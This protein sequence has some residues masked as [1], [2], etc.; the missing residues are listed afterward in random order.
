[1]F[2]SFD[3]PSSHKCLYSQRCEHLPR[4]HDCQLLILWSRVFLGSVCLLRYVLVLKLSFLLEFNR[5]QKSH[6]Q[7]KPPLPAFT[8]VDANL[9]IL[10]QNTAV[11]LVVFVTTL[12]RTP[13]LDE[14]MLDQD[15]EEEEEEGL[16]ASTGRRFGATW[17]DITGRAKKGTT[18]GND[19][20]GERGGGIG[21]DD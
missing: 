13:K 6:S 3:L 16:L 19:S 11:Y 18:S 7:K 8:S 4:Q 12:F 14:Y 2:G 15:A 17:Q 9:T 1:M 21:E 10:P 5:S 20:R